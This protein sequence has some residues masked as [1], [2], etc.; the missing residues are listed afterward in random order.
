MERKVCIINIG[1]SYVTYKNT[2][3]IQVKIDNS[4]TVAD[5]CH[6]IE[7]MHVTDRKGESLKEWQFSCSSHVAISPFG[8]STS[9]YKNI[10]CTP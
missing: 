9:P 1:V 5:L 6:E 8:L 7:K 4:N 3:S 10:H 2:I